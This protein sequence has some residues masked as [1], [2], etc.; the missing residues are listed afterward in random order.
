MMLHRR[1]RLAGGRAVLWLSLMSL[2]PM[3]NATPDI[4]L[5]APN[6]ANATS[7]SQALRPRDVVKTPPLPASRPVEDSASLALLLGCLVV[8]WRAAER[9][10]SNAPVAPTHRP[11]KSS[12]PRT[13][14][15]R[16]A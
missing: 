2:G 12:T 3:A 8:L 4:G 7:P 11:T 14:P 15:R 10:E 5:P 13:R 9:R 1:C 6:T 16:W